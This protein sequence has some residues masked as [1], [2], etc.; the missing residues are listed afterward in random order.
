MA[1][2]IRKEAT[3]VE[4]TA[5]T[6]A[7]EICAMEACG[8]CAAKGICSQDSGSSSKRVTLHNDGIPRNVGDKVTL[9]MSASMGLKGAFYAY[10]LPVVLVLLG[11]IAMQRSG[12]NDFV[13]GFSALGILALYFL[14]LWIFRDKIEKNILLTIE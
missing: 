3:V 13:S 7:L 14:L 10:F 4:I 1:K 12:L 2:E 6:I 8:S 9:V 11:I 5:D